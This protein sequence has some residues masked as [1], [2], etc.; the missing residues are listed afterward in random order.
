MSL[1][2]GSPGRPR[3]PWASTRRPG[4]RQVLRI[5]LSSEEDAQF[6]HT[7]EVS[8]EEFQGLKAEQGIL[9]DFGSFPGKVVSLLQKCAAERAAQPPRCPRR[10]PGARPVGTLA[11]LLADLSQPARPMDLRGGASY[12]RSNTCCAHQVSQPGD[13]F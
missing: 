12:S 1:V 6:L 4:A 7:L 5:Q 8:E 2:C 3:A 11:Q 10:A 13:L 9:V